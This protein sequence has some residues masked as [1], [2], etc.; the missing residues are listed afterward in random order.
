MPA[1]LYSSKSWEIAGRCHWASEMASRWESGAV[2]S[3]LCAAFGPRARLSTLRR[4]NA[5]RWNALPVFRPVFRKENRAWVV[6]H[7]Y[8]PKYR[9]I[10]PFLMSSDG[11][12]PAGFFDLPG[13]LFLYRKRIII[14]NF[15]NQL[16]K[17]GRSA[18]IITLQANRSWDV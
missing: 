12:R 16:T 17:Y 10:P 18:I 7:L 6:V 13:V 15:H 11:K 9:Y 3:L 14:Q 4:V 5:S 8:A 2:L 1:M